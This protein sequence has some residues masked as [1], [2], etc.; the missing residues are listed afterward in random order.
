MYDRP[1]VEPY[2]AAETS[3]IELTTLANVV[4][5]VE[6]WDRHTGRLRFFADISPTLYFELVVRRLCLS[7]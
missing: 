4:D 6:K 7:V 1:A 3:E 2:E 5:W